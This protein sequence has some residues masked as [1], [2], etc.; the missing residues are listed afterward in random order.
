M[1]SEGQITFKFSVLHWL[2]VCF[3]LDHAGF[4]GAAALCQVVQVD[5]QACLGEAG[6]V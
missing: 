3:G 6:Q 2:I 4:G 5:G 1:A